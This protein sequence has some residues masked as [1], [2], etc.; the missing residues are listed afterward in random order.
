MALA[1][2]LAFLF[3]LA[4]SPSSSQLIFLM[5]PPPRLSFSNST[6]ASVSCAAHGTPAPT[7]TWLTEDGVPVSDVPGLREAL[8][9]G[10]LWL[11]A[12]SA[13]QYRSDVHAAVLRCRAAGTVGTVLSRD[14]RLEAAT[15]TRPC[16]AAAPR[17]PWAPCCR[18]T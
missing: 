17:A 1:G 14:M 7:I 12:F 4:A 5:E 9:N 15:C 16:S 8:P 18:A 3:L 6:G 13:A 2:S 11:G 10:T